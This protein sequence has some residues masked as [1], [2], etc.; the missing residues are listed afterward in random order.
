MAK[1]KVATDNGI[2]VRVEKLAPCAS[3]GDLVEVYD[4]I[5]SMTQMDIEL[6]SG[7]DFARRS[8]NVL[9]FAWEGDPAFNSLPGDPF[10]YL[11]N[12]DFGI[13]CVGLGTEFPANDSSW[14]SLADLLPRV[15]DLSINNFNANPLCVV[16]TEVC[17]QF[18]KSGVLDPGVYRTLLIISLAASETGDPRTLE[19]IS[20]INTLSPYES[21]YLCG[22]AV[23]SG[24]IEM[25]VTISANPDEVD[26]IIKKIKEVQ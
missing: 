17:R 23:E 24:C 10:K 14:F 25:V 12:N 13:A 22:P 9:L 6:K 21:V 4:L 8:T 20:I 19:M 15:F 16:P 3:P 7:I 26:T 2:S 1:R 18:I 5:K 11:L